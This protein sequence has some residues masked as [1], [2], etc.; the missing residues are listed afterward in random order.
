MSECLRELAAF[1]M[2]V[3][4]IPK[5]TH[6]NLRLSQGTQHPLQEG[7]THVWHIDIHAGKISTHKNKPPLKKERK[8]GFFF[9]YEFVGRIMPSAGSCCLNMTGRLISDS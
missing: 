1:A 6:G 9:L 3:S 4:L 5:S 2:D 7:T 8:Y